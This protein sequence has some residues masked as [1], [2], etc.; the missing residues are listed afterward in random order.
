MRKFTFRG[1]AHPPENKHPT[2]ASPIETPPLPSHVAI[3]LHQHIGAPSKPIVEPGDRVKTGTVIGEPKGFVSSAVH[4]SITGVVIEIT[5][6]PHPAMPQLVPCVI[7]EGDGSD[8]WDNSM[9]SYKDWSTLEPGTIQN[10]VKDAGIVGLGGAAFPTHVKLSPPPEKPIDTLILNGAECEPFLT[11][12]HRIMLERAPDIIEA[13]KII[14]HTLRCQRCII[15]IEDNKPDA[16]KLLSDLCANED[17]MEVAPLKTKYPQGAEHQIIMAILKREV[18]SGGLPLDIGVVVQNVGTACAIYDALVEGC[19]LVE[20]I[21]SVGGPKVA[22]PRNLK[23][24]IGTSFGELIAYCEGKI[25]EGDKLLNGGP[26]MGIAQYTE[27]VPVV[28]GTSGIL[29]FPAERVDTQPPQSCIRC[30][31]CV[32]A[33]PMG[34]VPADMARLIELKFIDRAEQMGVLDCKE[35][36]TCSYVCPSK[37]DHVHLFKYAKSEIFAKRRK[38]SA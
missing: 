20:R 22:K 35:C 24:R 2:E 1:G 23:V 28:K 19:P 37:I 3:P 18:P 16:I 27:D 9:K 21:V 26:M 25:E 13:G 17:N 36:G 10:I 31:R 34:L 29:L 15:A 30:A 12:D 14:R 11:A 5:P 33:C 6:W 4:A 7:I 38:K 8:D 32:D